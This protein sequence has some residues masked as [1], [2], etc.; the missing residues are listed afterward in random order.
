M[1]SPL[2]QSRI[3]PQASLS[4]TTDRSFRLNEHKQDN[5]TLK[6]LNCNLCECDD[7][8]DCQLDTTLNNQRTESRGRIVHIRLTCELAGVCVGGWRADLMVN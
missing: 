4:P 2:L 6:S 5:P 1:L 3:P 7:Q 8:L